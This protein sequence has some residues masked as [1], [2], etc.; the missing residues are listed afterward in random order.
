MVMTYYY[1]CCW[2]IMIIIGF[3]WQERHDGLL[4]IDIFTHERYTGKQ[5]WLN[6]NRGNVYFFYFFYSKTN[7]TH[8][9]SDLFYFG[10][11]FYMFR[12]VLPSIIRSLRLYIQHQ[13]PVW[14]I[15]D[16]V[17]T[18]LDS[19]QL[20]EGPSETCRVLFQNKINRSY[21]AFIL[22]Y[23]YV[24]THGNTNV[25]NGECCSQHGKG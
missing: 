10:T 7:K 9:S 4:I 15:P 2:I 22:L 14:H 3:N 18:V 11:T 1:C 12:T 13:V 23:K 17:C 8:N 20:T 19:W 25:K 6:F 21:C 24:M 5:C 16:A